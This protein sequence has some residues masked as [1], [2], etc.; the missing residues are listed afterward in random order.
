MV[1]ADLD[2]L[3]QRYFRARGSFEPRCRKTVETCWE[4]ISRVA[5]SYWEVVNQPWEDAT[6]RTVEKEYDALACAATSM[7]VAMRGLSSKAV[8]LAWEFSHQ[9]VAAEEGYPANGTQS[10][11]INWS[12]SRN[13]LHSAWARCEGDKWFTQHVSRELRELAREYRVGR[14]PKNLEPLLGDQ[15]RRFDWGRLRELE[16]VVTVAKHLQGIA[17]KVKEDRTK[18]GIGS[19]WSAG[20]RESDP[21]GVLCR[22]IRDVIIENK[23]F[24]THSGPIS[25]E[26]YIWA[27]STLKEEDWPSAMYFGKRRLK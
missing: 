21:V 4:G 10:D 14:I 23:G 26:I 8:S 13:P 25:R 15:K 6:P 12:L 1:E 19:S 11:R 7:I 3:H 22:G 18:L 2:E 20:V 5:L 24:K 17:A 27:D 9:F 16:H